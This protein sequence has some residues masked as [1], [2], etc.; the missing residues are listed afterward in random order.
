MPVYIA[1]EEISQGLSVLRPEDSDG[2]GIIVLIRTH[3]DVP[4]NGPDVDFVAI[5]GPCHDTAQQI[6]AVR[7]TSEERTQSRWYTLAPA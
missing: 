2:P 5:S 4:A 3:K 1:R 6:C 7:R